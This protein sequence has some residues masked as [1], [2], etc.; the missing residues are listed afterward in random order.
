MAKITTRI[1]SLST[2]EPSGLV[3]SSVRICFG[4]S[5]SDGVAT[6]SCAWDGT[7]ALSAMRTISLSTYCPGLMIRAMLR[8][9]AIATVVVPM[10]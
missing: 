2:I 7:G 6:T 10:K 1:M 3:G 9:I 4:S 5:S 8:P